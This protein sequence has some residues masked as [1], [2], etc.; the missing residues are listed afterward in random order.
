MAEMDY[1]PLL[2]EL[3]GEQQGW[4]DYKLDKSDVGRK[5]LAMPAAAQRD[6]VIAAIAWMNDHQ[7]RAHDPPSWPVYSATMAL[8]RRRLP[9]TLDD[10]LAL[11]DYSARQASNYWR[12]LPQ[13]IKALENHLRE[14]ALAPELAEKIDFLIA[15]VEEGGGMAEERRWLARLKELAGQLTPRRIPLV[16]GEAWSDAALADLAAM[17]DAARSPWVQL[18][19]AGTQASAGT[20]TAKWLKSVRPL[21]EEIGFESFKSAVLKWF[22]LADKPRTAPV[23]SWSQWEPDPNLMLLPINADILRAFVWLCAE[24]EDRE[25]SHALAALARS[26]YR[27]VPMSGPRCV[28]LGNAC[29]WALGEMPGSAAIERL[30]FLKLKIKTNSA[31]RA[32]EKALLA[33]AARAGIGRDEIDEI[34][35]PDY[36]MQ[37][38]GCRRERLGDFTAE[39]TVSGADGIEL[40]WIGGDGK[41]RASVPAAVREQFPEEL[42][43]LKTA[44]RE[45]REMLGAQR[46][47]IENLYLERKAWRYAEWRERYLD[48]PLVG[49]IARRLIWRFRRAGETA[50]GIW[51]EGRIVGRD[52]R[53]IE[54]LD[55]KTSVGTSVESSKE[56]IVES[57]AKSSEEAI[58]E[59]WHPLDETTDGVMAWRDW[60]AAGEIRQPFKQAHREIY[61]LTDA[62]RATNTYSNRFAGHI[63]KQHQ[64][65][66]LCGARNWNNKL[67]LLVDD[68]YPP[69][70][71]RMPAWNLRA[72][73]WIEGIGDTYDTDTTAS[74]AYLYL[75]TDQVRFY[76]LDAQENVAHAGGGGYYA[77]RTWSDGPVEALPLAEIPPLVFSEIMRDVDLFVGVASVA[78]DP[79]WADGGP[80][81]RHQNYWASHAF[82]SLSETAKTRAAVLERLLPR[83]KIAGRCEVKERFLVVRGDRRTYKIH[84][85][86]GNI[87]MEPND[88]Y[89]CIVPA[90]GAGRAGKVFLPFEGDQM[91]SIILSKALLL[92]QDSEITDPTILRQI[93]R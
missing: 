11:V 31:A 22:P 77:R 62:E 58:V 67:R 35:V 7:K 56:T 6:F 47:R 33:A 28:R 64:F 1:A 23:R 79:N 82:G 36:G 84:L 85:G 57:S 48:H 75:S 81:G 30:A 69:A 65:N 42:K 86:S 74:G 13:V 5:L 17:N 49:L 10:L 55:E 80:E 89:L 54:W 27:K 59:L 40:V 2:D 21:Y 18:M 88:Q 76:R 70:T 38:V 14:H 73:F 50:S 91:F 24:R 29:I 41:R 68:E 3:A 44:G 71:R 93:V 4:Y 9:F 12:G 53:A 43:E 19:H 78:N 72:E 61:L 51:R 20:P 15:R 46:D 34:S 60:L 63:I 90:Q 83:L 26:A 16:S 45:I 37:E 92:A 32:I 66:A 87:L 8:M 39:L 52:G 25:I